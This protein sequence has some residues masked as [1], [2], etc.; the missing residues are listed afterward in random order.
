MEKHHPSPITHSP[1]PKLGRG[2][3]RGQKEACAASCVAELSGRVEYRGGPT[4]P[5]G[6]LAWALEPVG[7]LGAITPK[8]TTPHRTIGIGTKVILMKGIT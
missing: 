3:G 7:R 1:L 5:K 4:L 6:S 8:V 2:R